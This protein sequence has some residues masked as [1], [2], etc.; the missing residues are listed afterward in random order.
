[1]RCDKNTGAVLYHIRLY[2]F[3]PSPTQLLIV[4][5]P[6]SPIAYLCLA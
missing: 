4:R 1:M 6:A 5:L 2:A 3:F